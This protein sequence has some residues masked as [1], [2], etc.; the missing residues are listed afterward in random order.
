[1]KNII[2]FFLYNEKR[3]FFSKLIKACSAITVVR[4]KDFCTPFDMF[5][6]YAKQSTQLDPCICPLIDHGSRQMNS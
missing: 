1:M 2:I 6:I 5:M 3:N 4:R